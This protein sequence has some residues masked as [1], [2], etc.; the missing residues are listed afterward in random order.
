MPSSRSAFFHRSCSS[1]PSVAAA[2]RESARGTRMSLSGETEPKTTRSGPTA[3]RAALRADARDRVFFFRIDS[4]QGEV[5]L[6]A[7]KGGLMRGAVALDDRPAGR[8]PAG[9]LVRRILSRI[10][11]R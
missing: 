8:Q 10:F 11:P 6:R 1:S 2:A 3:P 5:A 9:A 4:E 7:W